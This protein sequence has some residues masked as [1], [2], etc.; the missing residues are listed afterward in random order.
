VKLGAL[1]ASV[2]ISSCLVVTTA[3]HTE[4]QSPQ[5]KA[6]IYIGTFAVT[7]YMGIR[8]ADASQKQEAQGGPNFT[9]SPAKPLSGTVY[10][11]APEW[12]S[13]TSAGYCV[14][15]V[16][17]LCSPCDWD[18]SFCGGNYEGVIDV[19]RGAMVR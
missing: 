14:S 3:N 4:A 1:A 9:P 16:S 17:G 19:Q 12:K 2:G 7:T 13:V 11:L 18:G 10:K 6:L 15:Y 8:A 5:V